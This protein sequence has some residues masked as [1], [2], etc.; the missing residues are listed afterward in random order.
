V[1]LAGIVQSAWGLSGCAKAKGNSR[2]TAPAGPVVSRASERIRDPPKGSLPGM[3]TK[4]PRW[5]KTAKPAKRTV[6][7]ATRRSPKTA[8]RKASPAKTKRAKAKST[9][10]PAT[11]P[12]R[13]T[14]AATKTTRV[15]RRVIRKAVT[16]TPSISVE[17]EQTAVS[18]AA[19][20]EEVSE[21][22]QS[23][24]AQARALPG[25]K[26]PGEMPEQAETGLKLP[27]ILLE[28]D[29]RT[30]TP[31]TGPGQKYALGPAAA[32]P[33]VAHEEAALPEAYGT[34]KL[35]LAA[36][37]PRWLYAHWDLTPSQQRQYNALSADRHLVVRVYPRTVME[38]P[39]REVHVHPESRHWFIHVEHAETQYVAEPRILPANG[40]TRGGDFN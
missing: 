32:G 16:E 38:R 1:T 33:Q 36:R 29:E 35:L 2:C 10:R 17:G 18:A 13:K 27:P 19:S 37:D 28:G 20:P 34:G 4:K 40:H 5:G 24:Q 8:R 12:R 9:K 30:S 23:E 22:A 26:E 14:R 7:R 15:R 39:V 25:A 3:K 6:R 11:R 21:V 31:L